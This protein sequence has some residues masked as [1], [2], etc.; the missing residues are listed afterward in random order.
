MIKFY[1]YDDPDITINDWLKHIPKL[2][3]THLDEDLYNN[4]KLHKMRTLD[5]E[6]AK[7]FIIGIPMLKSFY[8]DSKNHYSNMDKAISKVTE[9]IYFKKYNGKDHL[10]L[11]DDWKFCE[12]YEF[13]NDS[14]FRNL[15]RD[16]FQDVTS[17]R[18][19]I[20]GKSKWK[21]PDNNVKS[22]LPS[23]VFKRNWEVTKY[24]IIVEYNMILG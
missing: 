20:I 1:L 21:D 18:Y 22:I 15:Y 12:W 4:F 16:K 5:P 14:K 3:R 11:A 6:K 9:S 10:I 24:N 17:T 7:V 2:H 19:E 8:N 13:F 23:S